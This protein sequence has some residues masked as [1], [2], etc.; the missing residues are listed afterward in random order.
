MSSKPSGKNHNAGYD[1][2]KDALAV[3]T[4]DIVRYLTSLPDTSDISLAGSPPVVD[5]IKRWHEMNAPFELPEDLCNF[6]SV[7][8]GL[9]LS[10]N[11]N[12]PLQFSIGLDNSRSKQEHQQDVG[13]QETDVQK[14][15]LVGSAFIYPLSRLE[16]MNVE[17]SQID[18]SN[19]V[20][21]KMEHQID[22]FGA[23]AFVIEKMASSYGQVALMFNAKTIMQNERE[24]ASSPSV[25]FQDE[26]RKWFKIAS[27]FTGY[28]RLMIVHLGIIGW[29]KTFTASG[30]DDR[31]KNNMLRFAR[32]RLT[33]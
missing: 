26:S 27:N 2:Q 3:I 15:E 21:S 32:E 28:F 16:R 31:C 17:P 30:V 20:N 10:W 4:N 18:P 8:N 12:Y 29:Q 25:W 33:I 22:K 11:C 19:L 7:T 14:S 13:S 6:Y 24:C 23:V 9:S 5:E 1:F